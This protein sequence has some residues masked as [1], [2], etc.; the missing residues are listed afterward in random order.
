VNAR[1][2]ATLVAV[3]AAASPDLR[4]GVRDVYESAK[5]RLRDRAPLNPGDALAGTMLA[6]ALLFYRAERGANPQVRAYEDAL[7]FVAACLTA[8]YSNISASTPVGKALAAWLMGV[9]PSL[10]LAPAARPQER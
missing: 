3:A 1:A 2:L 4:D 5:Q 7:V 8:G 10:A 9:G 6:S